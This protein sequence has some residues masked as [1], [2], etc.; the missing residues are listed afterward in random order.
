MEIK[1]LSGALGAEIKGLDLNLSPTD[2]LMLHG[3][4]SFD[5]RVDDINASGSWNVNVD[6]LILNYTSPISMI[7]KFN[8]IEYLDN[9]LV[10][11]EDDIYFKLEHKF[12]NKVNMFSR[13][14][15]QSFSPIV[16]SIG[17]V[18]FFDITKPGNNPRKEL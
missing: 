7:R 16:A 10:L 9:Q 8:I 11:T 18:I 14:I 17:S 6:T 5:Y 4:Y 15:N 12:S 1:L 2:Y 13:D 3:D